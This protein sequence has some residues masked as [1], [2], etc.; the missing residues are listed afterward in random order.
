MLEQCI[1]VIPARGGSKGIPRKNLQLIHGEPLVVRTV[2]TALQARAVDRVLVSTDD[3]EIAAVS[4]AAGA[5]LIERPAEL[6]GDS[7][8]SEVAMLHALDQLEAA[9][10]FVPEVVVLL[11]CTSP[12]TTDE[13]IDGTI[14]SL[15][16]GHADA[17]FTATRNHNFLWRRTAEG[18][19]GAVNHN[20]HERLPRQEAPEQFLET[21]AVYAMRTST[22][23]SQRT[24]FCGRVVL[25]EVPPERAVEIDEGHDLTIARALV[26]RLDRQQRAVRL[27]TPVRGVIFDFDGVLTDDLVLTTED[28]TEAVTCSR[29]DGMGIDRLRDM[30]IPV[31]VLSKETNPV[32]E[33]RCAKLRVE[34]IQ[35]IRDKLPVLRDWTKGMCMDMA[36]VVY[37]GNDINDLTCL[38]AVGCGVVVADAHPDVLHAAKIVLTSPGGRGAVRELADMIYERQ[39]VGSA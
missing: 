3:D 9:E 8:S 19:A 20:P 2:R 38:Q 25:F 35:G 32:V 31:L 26:D 30:D 13:D 15:A 18:W 36:Q 21:G 10:N 16:S 5:D 27:P 7:A 17:A 6:A 33:A 22:F 11:Q 39:G 28:G 14:E 1:A 29:R 34:C 23:R 4:R 12:L 37:V 24:R